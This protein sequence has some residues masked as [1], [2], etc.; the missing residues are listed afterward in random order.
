[1]DKAPEELERVFMIEYCNGFGFQ[2]SNPYIILGYLS[3]P[4][5]GL[6]INHFNIVPIQPDFYKHH[7]LRH[8]MGNINEN[9][10]EN[11]L[12]TKFVDVDLHV[13]NF[14]GY[15]YLEIH[16]SHY[17]LLPTIINECT[18]IDLVIRLRNKPGVIFGKGDEFTLENM[19]NKIKISI[20]EFAK[21]MQGSRFKHNDELYKFVIDSLGGKNL[22]LHWNW[23]TQ[24][25]KNYCSKLRSIIGKKKSVSATQ[26]RFVF[27]DFDNI[28]QKYRVL[29][30]GVWSAYA[31]SMRNVEDFILTDDNQSS[32]N[33]ID[34]IDDCMICLDNKPNTLV[35]PCM[36]CVVCKE[37]SDKLVNTND[38]NICVR[39][40]RPI[41]QVLVDGVN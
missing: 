40:R 6:T 24:E 37:C 30:H 8:V 21:L 32:N 31:P 16:Y 20:D 11:Y 25:N 19:Q 23:I 33:E 4:T 2:F 15:T 41:D 34:E 27:P 5:S 12:K 36:H 22:L 28:C 39:C 7:L 17:E 18:N 1:M 29:H 13:N 9:E 26:S 35:L 3:G 10:L 38:K 14:I